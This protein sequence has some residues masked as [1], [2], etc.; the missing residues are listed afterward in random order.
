MQFKHLNIIAKNKISWLFFTIF[1]GMTCGFIIIILFSR[2]PE[3]YATIILLAI[4]S[5]FF[6]IIIGDSKRLLLGILV[7]CL[8][9]SID[10]TFGYTGHVGGA[11]GYIVSFY[12]IVLAFSYLL[13]FSELIF[14]KKTN[15][16]LFPVISI[17][18]IFLISYACLST[19]SAEYPDYSVYEIIEVIK[20]YLTF[21]Y[22]ANNIKTK[23]DVQFILTVFITCLF[24]EGVLGWAQH[25]YD[26]P[27]FP[28]ALGGPSW[29]DSRVKG[30][31]VSYNDFAWYLTCFLPIAM[32]MMVSQIK[33]FYKLVC[34]VTLGVA[35]AS[36][37]WTNSR[38]GWI[39]FAV[40]SVFVGLFVFY[41]IED[42]KSLINLF[43]AIIFIIIILFPLYPRLFSKTY[44]RFAGADKGSTKSRLPQ[45]EIAFNII[46]SH[47][48]LGIGINNYSEIMWKY[49]NTE[50]GLE[51]I[52]HHP[53]HNIFLQIAA[54]M[55]IPGLSIFIWFLVV[56][57][58][59]GVRYIILNEGFMVYGTIGMLAGIL[60]FL[61]HGLYDVASMGSKMF[62]F[63]WFFAGLIF[64]ITRIQ[65]EE[66]MY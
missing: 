42:K 25:R 43:F 8:P 11:A 34:F 10:I 64:A 55:G 4:I 58:Y 28:T 63:T 19:I 48:I 16:E 38:S 56:I 21:I 37:M 53:V 5:P 41:K 61:I 22:L 47:P 32:S 59:T 24:L 3:T 60:A 49:D 36:L 31:W 54:E 50:E 51:Q 46:K 20:M 29:V 40:A 65:F 35:S 23:N 44:G 2:L 33:P 39:S 57:F 66:Q 6:A 12:D 30:T 18:A 26:R 7:V 1:T 62:L 9:I 13:W 27:F 14:K 17:P 15:I 45:F 52:S